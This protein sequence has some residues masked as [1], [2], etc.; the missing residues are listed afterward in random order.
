MFG[1]RK[2]AAI[3]IDIKKNIL[4]YCTTRNNQLVFGE[5]IINGSF[6]KNG[7]LRNPEE[8]IYILQQIAAEVHRR[9]PDFIFSVM[10]E[11]LL[12]RQVP[13]GDMKSEKEI[14]EFLYFELGESISLP[15][16]N[17]IFDLLIL[18]QQNKKKVNRRRG[19]HRQEK[20]A[21]RAVK[22][23][24]N[25]FAV[26]GKVPVV[27]TSAPLIEEV[28]DCIHQ[29]GGQLIG[30]D[31]SALVYSRILQKRINWGENFLLVE[32][33]AGMAT[34]T[35]FEQLVPVYVQHDDYNQVNWK[36]LETE[37]GVKTEFNHVVE[38]EELENLGITIRNVVHY[39][40]T[41]ISSGK[42]LVQIYLV[43]GHPLLTKEV[44]KIIQA[45]NELPVK[46]LQSPLRLSNQKR[47][48]ERFLLAAGLSMKEV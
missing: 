39:F 14:R 36:F 30:V 8:F 42:E 40:E 1:K 46:E 43:G 45:T 18:E 38:L 24:R 7:K 33:D 10:N 23:Q 17:P 15:F 13:L 6:F 34:I 16:D 25:R 4:R 20:N 48:P 2:H 28:G 22:I 29:S 27:V 3:G 19:R 37:H 5:K 26:N 11:K 12:I 44:L 47:L 41:E 35:I 32:L 31:C 9:N 21:K